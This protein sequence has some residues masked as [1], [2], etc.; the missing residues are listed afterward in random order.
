MTV[1][2]EQALHWGKIFLGDM[3]YN[4]ALNDGIGEIAISEQ[5]LE[6]MKKLIELASKE[7]GGEKE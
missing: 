3:Y 4:I 1:T 6:G 5:D 7:N 2:K